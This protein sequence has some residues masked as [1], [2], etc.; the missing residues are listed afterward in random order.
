MIVLERVAESVTRAVTNNASGE[1]PTPYCEENNNTKKKYQQSLPQKGA[2]GFAQ[3]QKSIPPRA[4]ELRK[5]V[6]R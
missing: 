6:N 2:V 5:P 3:P 4:V 1:Q